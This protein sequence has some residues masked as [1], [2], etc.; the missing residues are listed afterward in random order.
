D[1]ATNFVLNDL[2]GFLIPDP[3]D[4]QT[5][6][7]VFGTYPLKYLLMAHVRVMPGTDG[8]GV[9]HGSLSREYALTGSLI[10]YWK[11]NDPAFVQAAGNVGTQTLLENAARHLQNMA[12]SK[13][14]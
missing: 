9:E 4:E 12:G 2:P 13:R 14:H 7:G 3:E 6:A 8:A 11:T 10:R 5:V 1:P